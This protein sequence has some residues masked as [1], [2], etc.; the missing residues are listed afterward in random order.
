MKA[1]LEELEKLAL[2]ATPGPWR[3]RFD[4][5]LDANDYSLLMGGWF[6]RDADAAFIA[7]LNPETVLR[8]IEQL[9]EFTK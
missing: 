3:A 9:R 7:A 6:R 8:L 2:A 5:V 1:E 4:E